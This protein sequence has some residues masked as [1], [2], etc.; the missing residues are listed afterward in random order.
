[1]RFLDL[2][3]AFHGLKASLSGQC[4][5]D[6]TALRV[7]NNFRSLI[8]DYS[9]ARAAQVLT[10]NFTDYS[11]SVNELINNACPNGPQA[12][13]TATFNTRDEFIVGQGSQP[14]IPFELLN[15]W[16]N[17]DVITLRWKTPSPGTVQPE[18]QV[19]GI[20]VLEAKKVSG[21][22]PWLISTAYSEFNSGAWLYD[23]GIF[24]P[25][26]NAT[27]PTEHGH[28]PTRNRRSVRM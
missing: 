12:L 10:K 6:G 14:N 11:D 28:S 19:T 1:M 5:N 26:C 21:P 27:S 20:I 4:L 23:L 2:I 25:T 7:A 17:C 15:V 24:Q 9:A 18:Q 13:G 16:H 3:S 22:E 8:T